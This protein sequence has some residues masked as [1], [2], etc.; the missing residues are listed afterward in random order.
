M[1]TT[2]PSELRKHGLQADVRTILNLYTLMSRGLIGNLGG[3]YSCGERI[4]VKEP[5]QK[6]P[7]TVAFSHTSSTYISLLAN[8]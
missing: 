7:F 1:L 3:L 6:G 2:F 4:V 8:L 5:R